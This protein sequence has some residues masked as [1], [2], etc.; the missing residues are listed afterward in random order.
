ML[1][2]VD[3]YCN[4]HLLE[5][6]AAS[7]SSRGPSCATVEVMTKNNVE[8]QVEGKIYGIGSEFS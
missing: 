8:E 7:C 2:L 6:A 1:G 4:D 3:Q 5:E